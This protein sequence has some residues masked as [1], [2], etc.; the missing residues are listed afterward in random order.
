MFGATADLLS[1]S[2]ASPVTQ[3]WSQLQKKNDDMSVFLGLNPPGEQ[4]HKCGTDLQ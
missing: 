2:V 3:T 4:H 1:Q